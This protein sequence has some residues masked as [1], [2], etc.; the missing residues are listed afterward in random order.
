MKPASKRAKKKARKVLMKAMGSKIRQY[1][2][3]LG[4]P[5]WEL[6]R[7][8]GRSAQKISYYENG[9]TAISALTLQQIA[10]ALA[11]QVQELFP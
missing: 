6:G 5:Q 10:D 11:V 3:E 7:I 4:M 1:R 9:R 2:V 8:I